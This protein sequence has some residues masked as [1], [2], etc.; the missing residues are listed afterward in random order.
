MAVKKEP[1]A[2]K[3]QKNVYRVFGISIPKG[4]K[5]DAAD[6]T[7]NELSNAKEDI[8]LEKKK[9]KKGS[10]RIKKGVEPNQLLSVNSVRPLFNSRAGSPGRFS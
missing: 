1:K 5:Y 3:W 8:A 7:I 6:K 9:G 10:N 4:L 2:D